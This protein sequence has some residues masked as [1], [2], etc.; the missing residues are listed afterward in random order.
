MSESGSRPLQAGELIM[1]IDRKKR[2]YLTTLEE[3]GEFHSHA[4]ALPHADL[5]G[6]QEGQ[7]FR[8]VKNAA[9]VSYTHLTLPTTPYV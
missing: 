1:L 9:S 4:G 3:G 7:E 6:Q 5:I 8:S 2:R